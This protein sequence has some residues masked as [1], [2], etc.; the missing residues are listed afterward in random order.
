MQ[1]GDLPGGRHDHLV[2]VRRGRQVV[3]QAEEV[4]AKPERPGAPRK[5][6]EQ[7]RRTDGRKK[8]AQEAAVQELRR[9]FQPQLEAPV[10]V[11]TCGVRKERIM[12]FRPR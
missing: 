11:R 8:A 3:G 7:R 1:R 10:R 4:P 5:V 6:D 2:Y 9:Q 12:L